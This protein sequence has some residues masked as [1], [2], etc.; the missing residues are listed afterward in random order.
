MGLYPENRNKNYGKSLC[1]HPLNML[2]VIITATHKLWEKTQEFRAYF[3]PGDF[4][5]NTTSV[6]SVGFYLMHWA[7]Q[8]GHKEGQLSKNTQGLCFP[9]ASDNLLRLKSFSLKA[10]A[11]PACISPIISSSLVGTRPSPLGHHPSTTPPWTEEAPT[12]SLSMTSRNLHLLQDS[13][14]HSVIY[15]RWIEAASVTQR[16]T[17]RGLTASAKGWWGVGK[18]DAADKG[19]ESYVSA[20]TSC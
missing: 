18:R 4:S 17:H 12:P 11:R 20:R 8:E 13:M 10:K 3:H 2:L 16:L 9:K 5:G 19:R 14:F 6:Q 15:S 1:Y 7:Y